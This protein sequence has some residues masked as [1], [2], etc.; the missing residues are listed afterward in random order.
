MKTGSIENENF[1]KK[2][3]LKYIEDAKLLFCVVDREKQIRYINKESCTLLGY[4]KQELIGKN[5]INVVEK[6]KR[7]NME[8]L[9]SG[10]IN[11]DMIGIDGFEIEVMTKE[12]EK[13]IIECSA[14]LVYNDNMDV[15]ELILSGSDKT[16]AKHL[17]AEREI[18][19]IEMKDRIREMSCIYDISMYMKDR[20]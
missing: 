16:T 6:E 3:A 4:E 9:L 10:I 8:I 15:E 20:S 1:I 13:R 19:L 14:A 12:G 11:E 18:M 2:N 17:E 7:M 5:I